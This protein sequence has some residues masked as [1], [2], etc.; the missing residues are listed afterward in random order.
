MSTYIKDYLNHMQNNVDLHEKCACLLK[1]IIFKEKR[2]KLANQINGI[3][4]CEGHAMA[5]Q[6]LSSL[7]LGHCHP[8]LESIATPIQSR[9]WLSSQEVNTYPF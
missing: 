2:V 9:T 3:Y 4:N 5:R 8:S 6:Y 7:G 1:L